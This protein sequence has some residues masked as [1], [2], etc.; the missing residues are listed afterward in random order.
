MHEVAA[1]VWQLTGR[2]RHWVNC[3][4]AGDVLID[5][6]TRWAERR[7]LRELGQ[8]PLHL[9]ALTHCHPDHQGCARVL[10]TRFHAPL[11]CHADDAAAVEGRAPLQP[12][13]RIIRF[14]AR[15]FGGPPC[16]VGRIL[17]D[18]DEVAGFRVIHAPGH[19]PGHV[20]YFRDAD[21]VAVAGDVFANIHFITGRVALQE[22]PSIFST[23][24]AQ[25]RVSMRLLAS[26]KPAVTCFGHGPP[27]RDPGQ[28]EAFVARLD[29][30]G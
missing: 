7:L 20:I 3:Y 30:Q 25:N 18:G 1:G 6:A 29:R 4:L 15:W 21:R 5:T 22:P 10:C 2:P 17:K 27:L 28:L 11:A 19:T 26:L 8:R 9:V 23:A 24:R 13:N 12:D 16:P 14:G